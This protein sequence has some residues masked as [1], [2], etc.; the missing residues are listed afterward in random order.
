MTQPHAGFK[1]LQFLLQFLLIAI[2]VTSL[3]ALVAPVLVLL[4]IVCAFTE[5]LGETNHPNHG[6]ERN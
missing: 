1:L 5:L 4:T 6:D 2:I 3:G